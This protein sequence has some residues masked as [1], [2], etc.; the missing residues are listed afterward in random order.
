MR[1]GETDGKALEAALRAGR[2]NQASMSLGRVAAGCGSC[3]AKYRNV[4]QDR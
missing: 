2:L 3:H 1:D 4:P